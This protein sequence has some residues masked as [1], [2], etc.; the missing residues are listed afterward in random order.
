[1]L[2]IRPDD[3]EMETQHA[4]CRAINAYATEVYW[5]HQIMLENAYATKG[6]D[7]KWGIWIDFKSQALLDI[8]GARRVSVRMIEDIIQVLNCYADLKEAQGRA[9]KVEDLYFSIE[10]ESFY[11]VYD[12]PLLVA[13]TELAHGYMNVFYAHTAFQVEPVIWHKHSEPFETSQCIVYTQDEVNSYL[14]PTGTSVFDKLVAAEDWMSGDPDYVRRPADRFDSYEYG[15]KGVLS[16]YPRYEY[17]DPAGG[18]ERA[19]PTSNSTA[20]PTLESSGPRRTQG[21]Y[22]HD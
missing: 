3:A 2:P 11:G 1:M 4:F 8:N 5:Y 12:D 14:Q 13:R 18:L 19:P 22:K 21:V 9:F 17:T 15:K 10:Y 6:L 20:T 16:N 7:G